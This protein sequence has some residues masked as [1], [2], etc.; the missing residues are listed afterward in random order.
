MVKSIVLAKLSFYL[1]Y[2]LYPHYP[3]KA[4]PLIIL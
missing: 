4:P 1:N 3:Q 2:L